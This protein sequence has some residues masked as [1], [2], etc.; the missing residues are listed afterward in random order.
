MKREGVTE[1]ANGVTV[2]KALE[3][4]IDGIEFV[5]VANLV[6]PKLTKEPISTLKQRGFLINPLIDED[7]RK[8]IGNPLDLLL[9]AELDGEI[10]GYLAAMSKTSWIKKWPEWFPTAVFQNDIDTAIRTLDVIFGKHLAVLPQLYRKGIGQQ[11]IDELVAESKRHEYRAILVEV[12][13]EPIQNV[14]S[15]LFLEM[16]EFT[17]IGSVPGPEQPYAWDVYTRTIGL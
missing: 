1:I 13:R 5:E 8:I 2:R 10:V 3:S 14:R 12:L 17:K 15:L 4:D 7:F 6:N 9:V 11:L 16:N